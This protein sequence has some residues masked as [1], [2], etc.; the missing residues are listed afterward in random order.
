MS[1]WRQVTRGLRVLTKR[2]VADRE[3]TD[4]VLHYVEQATAAGIAR[5]LGPDEARRAALLE[6]GGLTAVRQ[7]V[8]A[9]GWENEVGAVLADLRYG[10]RRLRA[11]PGF[12][13]ITVLTLAI[14]IGGTTA[15]FSAVNPILFESLPYPHAGRMVSILEMHGNGSRSDGTFA[16]FREF[17]E[18]SRS[19]DAIAV[20]K[21]WQPTV[22]GA[23]QPERFE[24]QRVSAGYFRVLGIVP[25]MGRD[26]DPSDDRRNGP[27]V[28]ILSDALWRRRFAGDHGIVGR[29][30]RLDDNLYTVIGVMPS[31]FENVLAPG[32]GVW[33]PLQYDPSLPP[34]GREWGHHLRTIGLLRPGTGVAGA[35]GEVNLL[36]RA[37]L[38]AQHPETYDPN[39]QFGVASL[40]DEL[41]RGVKPALLA[42]L[43][44]VMLVLVIACVNVTNLLLARGVQ[45][46]GEFALRAALG[47][48]RSRLVRQLLTESLLLAAM[49]GLVGIAVAMLGVRGLV[50]LSPPGL[51]RVGSIRVD[52]AVLAFGF[53]ITTLIGL[54]FGL[55]PALQAARHDPHHDL[56]L[57]SQRTAGGHRRTRNALVVA[58]V[59]LALMLLVSSGLLLRSMQRLFATPVGFDSSGL[60]T[61]QVQIVGHQFDD[62]AA[63]DLFFDQVAQSVRR[64][65]GIAAAGLTSQL[66]LSGDRDEYGAAFEAGP[67]QAAETY[68]A[69]RYAVSPGYL[70]TMRV[71]LRRGRLLDERDDA[72]APLVALI[73]ESL[74]NSRFHG[75]DPIG[76]RLRIGPA[77]PYTIVGVV[78]DL[79]Q[80]SLALSESDA[81][82]TPSTQWPFPPSVLS[83]VVRARGDAANTASAVRQAI[84]SVDKDQ[85]IVRVAT[86][87]DLLTTSAAERRF[88]LILFEAFALAALVLAAAGIYGVLA[89]SVAER[90]REI[91]VRSA[92]GA[93]RANIRNLVLGQGMTLTLVGAMIGLIG[94]IAASRAIVTLLFGVTRLDPVTY[95]GVLA[96]LLCVSAIACWVPAWRAARVDPVIT[97]RAE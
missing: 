18:R 92:L 3:V 30:I 50:A 21:P 29:Q 1:L 25:I 23:D 7:E 90:T 11:A 19:F 13:A 24:G 79:R 94:A 40:H 59:A 48:G 68:G 6:V 66:P 12:T 51:P 88:A 10:A 78:G 16:L 34:Q 52:A 81:V 9:Y 67:T 97:L 4:E 20:F 39:T 63:T 15:I 95:V 87:D 35:S 71:P 14:G 33:A 8:R 41:M 55:V 65:P 27:N 72:G 82:Y 58:E 53:G 80:V 60:L 84:W 17:A 54:A 2:S 32:A 47:A 38:A 44:A 70:E 61:M 93:S 89:G 36:G 91:G 5:G 26:F 46:R 73:S 77:G 31:G 49:G 64:V 45:R 42:I 56:Q 83:L 96:V 62:K 86:M 37:V 85:P 74:A 28:V 75:G 76:Q 69:F 22:T 57:G 43:G